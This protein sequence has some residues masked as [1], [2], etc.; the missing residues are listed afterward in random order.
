MAL[1]DLTRECVPAFAIVLASTLL[2][3]TKNRT[4]GSGAYQQALNTTIDATS[5]RVSL[6]SYDQL[7]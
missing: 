3:V 6:F 4:E 7:R 1:L 5:T 2:F